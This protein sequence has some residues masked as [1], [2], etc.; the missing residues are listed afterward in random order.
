MKQYYEFTVAASVEGDTTAEIDQ[1]AD[2]ML[3]EMIQVVC[4]GTEV[5]GEHKCRYNDWVGSCK[6]IED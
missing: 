2:D 3:E 1:L 5:D 6:P 4:Q